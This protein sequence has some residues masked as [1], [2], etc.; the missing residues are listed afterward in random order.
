M[1]IALA[2]PDWRIEGGFER[3][4]TKLCHG[5][6]SRG[7]DIVPVFVDVPSVYR[8]P[9][10]V[11]VSDDVWNAAPEYFRYLSLFE[12]FRAMEFPR[13]TD[14]LL[15]TQPPSFAASHRAHVSLFF[16]HA[17]MFYDLSD[18]YVAAG[19]VDGERH[20]RA[21]EIIR[22]VDRP[23]LARVDRFLVS[24]QEVADRLKSFGA[25]NLTAPFFPP[26]IVAGTAGNDGSP[27]PGTPTALCVSRHEFPKRAELFIQA[28][29]LTTG[30]EGAS[31]GTGGRESF[32]RAL[33]AAFASGRLDARSATA[34]EVWLNRADLLLESRAEGRVRFRGHVTDAE[35]VEW[36]RN[37]TCVVAPAF[38]EDYGL[39]ALEAMTFGK[40]VIVCKD[41]GGLVELVDDGVT[42][43]V[44]EPDAAAVADAITR[45]CH[46]PD[47]C[48]HMG[49]VARERM[50][51]Y[52]WDAAV[53][54]VET[55]LEA[56]AS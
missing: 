33:D 30:I 5:L 10:G 7:H 56:A 27:L 19:Y 26:P 3:V 44:V 37:A 41:G 12:V 53:E 34:E 42:G 11:P 36:Y 48:A 20:R 17:R 45:L 9:Y 25:G 21:S 4:L 15:S 31:V 49:A 28:I 46:D 32:A 51:P 6:R 22:E 24:S 43:F 1:R 13:D 55:S 14:V 39:T 2:K 54:Q 29:H 40:P 8:T 18:A 50:R 23:A 16:H 38:R 47:L 35:L 52:T